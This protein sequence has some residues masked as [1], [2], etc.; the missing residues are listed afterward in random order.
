MS[1]VEFGKA[2]DTDWWKRN[3][4]VI[5][6]VV[7]II[8]SGVALFGLSGAEDGQAQAAPANETDPANET[9]ETVEDGGL[10]NLAFGLELAGGTRVRAP[11][12]GIT[13]EGLAIDDDAP[14]IERDVANEL[15]L[16]EIDVM[17]RT[18]DPEFDDATVEVFDGNVTH[19]EL[20]DAL[21]A[22]GVDASEDDVR[23]GVTGET[24]ETAVNVLENKIDE[25]GLAGGSVFE[26]QT[27]GGDYFI[28]V[29]VPGEDRDDVIELI[30]ERGAVQVVAGHPIEGENG[31]EYHEEP[32]LAE[33]DFAG[34][35]AARNPSGEPPYVP[36]VLTAEAGERYGE[37]MRD[38]GFTDPPGIQSC[39]Y[40]P[41][42]EDGG[43]DDPG[44]CLYTIV[45]GE[46]VYA[47]SMSGDLAGSIADGSFDEQPSFRMTAQSMDDA[48]QLQINLQAG[49]LPAPMDMDSGT[50]FFL[51]PSLAEDFKIFSLIVGIIAALSVCGM[52]YARY[53]DVRVAVPMLLTASAEVV[54]LLG[55]SA[56]IGLP[57]DLAYIAGFIAVIGTGV[58]DLIIIADEVLSQGE[59]KTRRVFKSRFRKALWVIGAAAATTII[60]MSPLAI[61]SLGDLRGFAII[62]IIGVLIGVLIT[63]P[64]YGDILRTLMTER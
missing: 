47:A 13:A 29:E 52:V 2:L 6:L 31:T 27:A 64:A 37:Y 25:S 7:L 10:T 45:D 5:L 11:L 46:V 36:V 50:I 55:F 39:N 33:D 57:L 15:D 61:M 44:Y 54:I 49:S 51:E 59:V 24:R 38:N 26:T 20:A 14:Q 22:S 3:W 58:D 4:R 21:E 48:R 17:V 12:T 19:G 40:D 41:A 30:E 28:V 34:I 1:T 43:T 16:D 18:G 53:R 60:A 9:E 63:R 42:Q 62:T 23:D 8:A 35:D 56:A 32:L